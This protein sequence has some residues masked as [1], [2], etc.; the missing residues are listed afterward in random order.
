MNTPSENDSSARNADETANQSAAPTPLADD[1][2]DV[3]DVAL[4]ERQL[5]ACSMEEGCERC[6]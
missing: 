4:G 2:L 1:D 6:Q 5:A 3:S